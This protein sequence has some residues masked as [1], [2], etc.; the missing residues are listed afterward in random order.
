MYDHDIGLDWAQSNMAIARVTKKGRR[1]H[2]SEYPSDVGDLKAYLKGLKGKKRLVFEEST[3]SQW[4]YTELNSCVDKLIVCDPRRNR[5]MTEGAK[6][7][8]IDAQKLVQL[9]RADAIKPV[10]HSG[11]DF[12][13]LRKLVSG[14][15]DIV[16]AGVRLKNQRAAIFRAFGKDKKEDSIEDQASQFVLSVLDKNIVTYE[17]DK[18]MYVKEFERLE[19]KYKVIR[20]LKSTPG[21]KTINAVK[22]AAIVVDPKRFPSKSHFLAYCGLIKY[23]KLSGGRSYGKRKAAYNRTLK[24]VFDTA[25]S[26]CINASDNNFLKKDYIYLTEVKRLPDFQ[27][28]HAL[29]RKAAI[30]AWGVM[31]SEKRF[32]INKRRKD[33]ALKK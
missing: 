8:K 28:R 7:D 25:A 6:D 3:S 10:F 15:T 33:K 23:D 27:A 26:A 14:Y 21:L 18:S 12:I 16:Q 20:L 17:N 11:D 31:K 29:A 2:T 5:L 24:N 19:K 22:V 32:N 30:L 4:L 1:I 9:L 13:H